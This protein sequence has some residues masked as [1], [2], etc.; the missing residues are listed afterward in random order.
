[1]KQIRDNV[2]LLLLT[3]ALLAMLFWPVSGCMESS[4]SAEEETS[5]EYGNYALEMENGGFPTEDTDLEEFFQDEDELEYLQPFEEY[6][7]DDENEEAEIN[8]LP[9]SVK[10]IRL[11]VAWGQ[12]PANPELEK[13]TNWDGFVYAKG[14]KVFVKRTL[15]YEKHDFF[16]PCANHQCVVIY[17]HTLP[18]HD[19]LLLTI[20]PKVDEDGTPVDDGFVGISFGGLYER[21]VPLEEL[22]NVSEVT[23]VDELGNRVVVHAMK[24]IPKCPAGFLHGFWKRLN[25][26]GG[27]FGGKWIDTEGKIAGKLAGLWGKRKNGKRVIFGLYVSNDGKFKG[28][29]AGTYIP[30]KDMPGYKADAQGGIFVALWKGKNKKGVG[31]LKG[32]YTIA[33]AG[34]KGT[35]M[36][37][38]KKFCPGKNLGLCTYKPAV[39]ED[40]A[41]SDSEVCEPAN[42]PGS[43]K[44]NKNGSFCVCA[45]CY[46]EKDGQKQTC[47]DEGKCETG[48]IEPPCT[49]QGAPAESDSTFADC[50]CE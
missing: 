5:V 14:A 20:V 38:W 9:T 3:A 1:M 16:K 13:P 37:K 6:T 32:H 23:T 7:A 34:G 21:I 26:K 4:E 27:I 47:L 19:G 11:L 31:V 50:E 36:G 39:D 45:G 15:K 49:C 43:C 46:K 41:N 22:P 28:L 25:P 29:I 8:A 30:F 2:H 18:H 48:A 10:P 40:C 33:P 24:K 35:F 42:P 17:S 44:C 12:L